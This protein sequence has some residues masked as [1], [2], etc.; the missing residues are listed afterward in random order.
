ML[1][2]PAWTRI[3]TCLI[4]LFGL[5]IALPNAL[6]NSVLQRAPRWL[7]TN[8]VAL[9]LDL[10]GGSYLLLEVELDQVQRDK[11]ESEMG[12]IRAGL[13]RARIGF[14]RVQL[15][16]DTI[17]VH[18]L[19]PQR[20]DDAKTILANLNPGVGGSV[21]TVGTRAYDMSTPGENTVVMKMTEAYKTQTNND[22]L[23][24]SVE[25]VR[26]RI[27]QTGTREAQ[28]ERQGDN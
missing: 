13:R 6:P 16:G 17:S 28:I 23:S 2:I 25:V 11:L 5:L 15:S 24:Q 1:Q 14:E 7:P 3:V 27:D 9:G 12:D 22:I 21:L 20:F 4:L 26:R 18:V 8:T 19:D 10:Q